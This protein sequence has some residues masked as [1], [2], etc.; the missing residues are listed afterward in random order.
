MLCRFI[1]GYFSK[2]EEDLAEKQQQQQQLMNGGG[3][4][5]DLECLY[6]SPQQQPTIKYEVYLYA[7]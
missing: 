4:V 3:D 7:M 6:Y 1:F 2:E 5:D